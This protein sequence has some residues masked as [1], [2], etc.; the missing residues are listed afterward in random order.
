MVR[1]NLLFFKLH[2]KFQRNLAGYSFCMKCSSKRF[3]LSSA[4]APSRVCDG[5]FAMLLQR[6][7]AQFIAFAELTKTPPVGSFVFDKDYSASFSSQRR[8]SSP[9]PPPPSDAP[10][11]NGKDP[12]RINISSQPPIATATP[13]F[14]EDHFQPLGGPF[15]SCFV[16]LWRQKKRREKREQHRSLASS[17][18]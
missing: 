9:P 18:S 1:T 10:M 12:T 8:D 15:L 4:P 16:R 3:Q 13:T 5:C 6:V 7:Q 14:D 17:S 11:P 2:A